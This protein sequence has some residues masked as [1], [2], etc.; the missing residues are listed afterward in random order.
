MNVLLGLAVFIYTAPRLSDSSMNVDSRLRELQPD[1]DWS[2]LLKGQEYHDKP[3]AN[4]KLDNGQL[5][6]TR[7]W[8]NIQLTYQCCGVQS[9]ADWLPFRPKNRTD[10]YPAS[11]CGLLVENKICTEDNI[12][13]NGCVSEI[14]A[15]NNRLSLSLTALIFMNCLLSVLAN[16]VICCHPKQDYLVI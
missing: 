12:W 11:C 9:P 2:A 10:Q 6:A 15:A 4:W 14:K 7:K 13:T 5:D 1:Y 16:L 3:D 8:D